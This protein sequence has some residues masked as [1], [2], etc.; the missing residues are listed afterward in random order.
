[1]FDRE[2]GASVAR[3]PCRHLWQQ[4][5]VLRTGDV[6][7]CCVDIDARTAVGNMYEES[8]ASIWTGER[9][10]HM[11]AMHLAGRADE[12][13]GCAECVDVFCRAY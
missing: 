2:R 13:P 11:R 6:V 7:P 3:V 5:I 12:L 4:L 9:L 8:L 1:M 10:Q